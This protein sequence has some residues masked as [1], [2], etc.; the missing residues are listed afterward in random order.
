MN[1]MYPN[2]LWAFLVLAIPI[3]IHLFNFK[4]YKTH[5]FSNIR[6]LQQVEQ[7]TKSTQ[8]LRNILILL[9]RVLAFSCLV[10]AF[11]HPY[12]KSEN[13]TAKDAI[14][15]IY[16]DNSHSMQAQGTEGEL[17]SQARESAKEIIENASLGTQFIVATNELSGIEKQA[18]SKIQAIEKVEKIDYAPVGK[19]LETVVRWQDGLNKD[20]NYRHFLISDFQKNRL[21]EVS[22]IGDLKNELQLIQMTPQS[23][24]NVLVDS[25]WFSSPIRKVNEE[26]QLFLR[27]QNPSEE[28]IEG[29][30]VEVKIGSF[31]KSFKVDVPAKGQ[32]TTSVRYKDQSLGWKN[33]SVKISDALLQFDNEFFFSYEVK[34]KANILLIQGDAKIKNAEIAIGLEKFYELTVKQKGQVGLGDFNNQDLVILDGLDEISSGLKN[35]LIDFSKTGGSVALFPGNNPQTTSWNRL[36]REL[37][38]PTISSTTSSGTK[39]ESLNH[40]TEF[41]KG[42]VKK[43]N[44]NIQFP[45]ISK[46]FRSNSNGSLG[47]KIIELKNG[48]PLLVQNSSKG[49]S[50]MFYSSTSS[51]WSKILDDAL[52]PTLI[53]RICE[54]SQRK[55]PLYLT[56]GEQQSLP[57]Y[58][59]KELVTPHLISG[60]V[61]IIPEVNKVFGVPFI[62]LAQQNNAQF[63]SGIYQLVEDGKVAEIAMNYGTKES[64]LSYLTPEELTTSLVQMGADKNSINSISSS[65]IPNLDNLVDKGTP[66]WKILIVLSIIF[67]LI[68]MLLVLFWKKYKVNENSN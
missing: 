2:F 24:N 32:K 62:S 67:V 15:S 14:I 7:Q 11:T 28:A 61:D 38:L 50:F 3:L 48:Q 6:F 42:I 46:A 21:D 64:E 1:F 34:N 57:I 30:D 40:E 12:F 20:H 18:I 65:E 43:Q 36:L 59:E 10:L 29:I 19:D 4:R 27:V 49:N 54:L 26:N 66:L 8:R 17:L 33:G 16:V 35:Y 31:T 44:E 37:E 55:T 51:E 53:L 23:K 63:S 13:G 9:S 22:K 45:L 5:Y 25:V 39:I 68:E 58:T 56:I 52:Y 41:V 60:E 47:M